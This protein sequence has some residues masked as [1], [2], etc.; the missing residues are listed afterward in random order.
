MLP[1]YLVIYERK[2]DHITLGREDR[3]Y[4]QAS[5]EAVSSLVGLVTCE[6]LVHLPLPSRTTNLYRQTPLSNLFKCLLCAY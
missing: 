6:A 3:P 5:S 2:I 4:T 1:T